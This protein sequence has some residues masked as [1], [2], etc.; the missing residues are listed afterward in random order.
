MRQHFFAAAAVAV[1]LI[2]SAG[3]TKVQANEMVAFFPTQ[4]MFGGG[5][6]F[7]GRHRANS[8]PTRVTMHRARSSFPRKS[9][10][11][12]SYCRIIRR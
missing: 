5:D 4:S 10:G 11:S 9:A 6:T 7:D 3:L 8:C 12:I 2:L 1:V